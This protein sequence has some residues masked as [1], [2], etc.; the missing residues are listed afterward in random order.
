MSKD[1]RVT[2]ISD[3]VRVLLDDPDSEWTCEAHTTHFIDEGS[4]G[5]VLIYHV[6]EGKI[7]C[8]D[9]FD[10]SHSQA[11]YLLRL[12]SGPVSVLEG[13]RVSKAVLSAIQIGEIDLHSLEDTRILMN[14]V[15]F[16]QI[17]RLKSDAK[18]PP[19]SQEE[20]S[21]AAKVFSAELA[22]LAVQIQGNSSL[23]IP[24]GLDRVDRKDISTDM[25]TQLAT[26]INSW[27][28]QI[29][30]LLEQESARQR[31]DDLPLAEI[32]FVPV[33]LPTPICAYAS[34]PIFIMGTTAAMVSTL[35]TTVGQPH[36]PFTAG[37]GGF[38]LGFP[39]FLS[40]FFNLLML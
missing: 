16:P 26:C 36:N 32:N 9:R 25:V 22:Q 23:G 28:T 17:E 5:E 39:L 24:P 7:L 14:S 18:L 34:P 38:I 2:W 21:S 19:A 11:V 4:K 1:Q 31:E 30:C 15:C 37:K 13:E 6:S 20:L 33:D 12:V 35:F 10:V 27:L 29:H 3:R 8:S 40:L